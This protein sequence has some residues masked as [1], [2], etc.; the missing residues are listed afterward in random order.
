MN[1][2][3]TATAAATRQHRRILIGV[4]APSNRQKTIKVTIERLV[5]MPKYGKFLR[6]RTVVHAHDERSEAK[7]GDRVRVMECRPMS[8]TKNWRL[9]EI[10]ARGNKE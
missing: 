9:V 2:A 3:A 7:P 10:I 1:S 4:V 5:K 6:R 8:R